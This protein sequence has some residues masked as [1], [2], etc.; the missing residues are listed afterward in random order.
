MATR[1]GGFR[2]ISILTCVRLA[3]QRNGLA[4][5]PELVAVGRVAR[6]PWG[7][8][9]ILRRELESEGREESG[10]LLGASLVLGVEEA[11]LLVR[12]GEARELPDGREADGGLVAVLEAVTQLHDAGVDLLVRHVDEDAGRPSI[13]RR[14]VGVRERG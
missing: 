9:E 11:D 14:T 12:V 6:R 2:R 13:P 1:S 4:A 7:C 10:D 3:D 5:E 8:R